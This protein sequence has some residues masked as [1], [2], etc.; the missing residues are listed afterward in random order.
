M[1][2]NVEKKK[3]ENE[4]WRDWIDDVVRHSLSVSFNSLQ[5]TLATRKRGFGNDIVD[6][7]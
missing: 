1:T 4:A 5:A 6:T 3:E 7:F 2:F